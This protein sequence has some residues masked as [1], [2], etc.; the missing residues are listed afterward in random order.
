MLCKTI[1]ISETGSEN[2]LNIENKCIR[3]CNSE[4]NLE[5]IL[6]LMISAEYLHI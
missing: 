3:S 4:T 6:L 2:A 5:K 1:H